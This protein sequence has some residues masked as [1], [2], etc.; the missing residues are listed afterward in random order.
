MTPSLEFLA[1]QGAVAGRFALVRELGRGGMGVV[2]LARDLSL[3]RD[4][5]I[6]LLPPHLGDDAT[7]RERFVREARTAAALQHPHIVPIH[8]VEQAGD[9]LY[10]VMAYIDGE[11]LAGRVQ[12]AGSLPAREAMQL[13]Q[14]LA[15]ALGYAHGRGVVH[16]DIKPEN[17]LL[18]RATGRPMLA[19]F[20]IAHVESRATLSEPDVALGSIAYVS[21]EQ[22]SGAAP[23]AR[24]DLY[25]LGATLYFALSGRSPVEAPSAMAMLARLLNDTTVPVASIR[26]DLPPA[27]SDAVNRCL[28]HRVEDRFKSADELAQAM[29]DAL[30]VVRPARPEARDVARTAQL[31]IAFVGIGIAGTALT[32]GELLAGLISQDAAAV[33]IG[34]SCAAAL[35]GVAGNLGAMG[36]AAR[37]GASSDEVLSVLSDEITDAVA[38]YRMVMARSELDRRSLR[39]IYGLCIA[40]AFAPGLKPW[41]LGRHSDPTHVFL[42]WLGL[43][44]L[45]FG[46]VGLYQLRGD[47]PAPRWMRSNLKNG[48][49]DFLST[50]GL[51]FARVL[52][53]ATWIQRLAGFGA[54]PTPANASG[55]SATAM[56][57]IDVDAIW[58]ELGASVRSRLSDVRPLARALETSSAALRTRLA[59]TDAALAGMPSPNP[60]RLALEGQR[61]RVQARLLE[62]GA[63]LESLR[64]DLLRLQAGLIE[65]VVLSEDLERVREVGRRVDAELEVRA[66]L[67]GGA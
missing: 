61:A 10:F 25:S 41:A 24:S 42:A 27:L 44:P 65:P 37:A 20:G 4:I 22:A 39:V 11:T 55:A 52:T 8:A 21:P 63:A 15:W 46:V 64:S 2:F 9:L 50:V 3:E 29:G 43:A 38:S 67:Q 32:G 31:S 60:E 34:L 14:S 59:A 57:R 17:I 49:G 56:L 12:R 16:R 5:A 58:Q 45:F 30:A 6:K 18:D 40:L 53:S 1:L 66:L 23:D 19:D 51:R 54:P 35:L 28:A 47:R 62:C 26:P 7:T 13:M 48:V 33:G 36:A